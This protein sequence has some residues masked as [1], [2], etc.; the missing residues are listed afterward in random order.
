[1]SAYTVG[2]LEDVLEEGQTE[3][4]VGLCSETELEERSVSVVTGM[5]HEV[6]WSTDFHNDGC[7][8]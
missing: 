4:E 8:R 6:N 3:G 1:M 7:R 2:S 5:A